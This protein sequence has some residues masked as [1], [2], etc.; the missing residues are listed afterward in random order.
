MT[1]K[2]S[3]EAARQY[4]DLYRHNSELIDR[5]CDAPALNRRRKDALS[6][7]ESTPFPCK[8]DE[9][10][11]KTSVE[12]IFA[13]DYGIN[14]AR[15]N[16]PVDAARSFKC[17]VPNLSTL[18]AFVVNDAFVPSQGLAERLPQGVT[19]MSLA[20]GAR[21]FPELV[22]EY[23]GRLATDSSAMVALNT[24]LLQDGVL[25]HIAKGTKV[26]KPL[27]LVNIFSAPVPLLAFRR[28]L[29]V[30]EEGAAVKLLVCDHTQDSGKAYCAS[31][32][33]EIFVRRGARFEMC[34][35]EESSALTSRMAQTYVSQEEGSVTNVNTT[36]LTC[37]TSRNEWR[38][39]LN[40]SHCESRLTGMAIGSDEMH[41]DNDTSVNH[42]APHC[43]SDQTFKYVLDGKSRGAFEG[44]ILVTP[45]AP[46]TEAYQ[47]TRNILA[48]PDARMHCKPQLEIYNDEVKCSH[49]ATTGQLDHEK[50]FYMRSR[51]I[52]EAEARTMLMQAFMIDI[53]ES[54]SIPG[55]SD[56]LRHL[57]ER[58]FDGTLGSCASCNSNC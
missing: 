17:D 53:I 48:S 5:A 10:Y 58:R 31:Q 3:S 43:H 36:T 57:V 51:G 32:V 12:E 9:G 41:I 50:I 19:F 33:A 7:F 2:K 14:V 30:V 15:K 21:R 18:A 25:I 42:N 52:P 56:R 35:I 34:S 23:Y 8:G 24:L 29:V 49:G 40:G 26:E 13:P 38:V 6:V 28:L 55:L 44:R 37:G 22:E 20:E 11:E 47:S 16:I 1:A 4:I 27:Q 54:V 39:S 45:E 46:F